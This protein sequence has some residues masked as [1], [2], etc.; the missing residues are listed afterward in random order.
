LGTLRTVDLFVT[1][2]DY[3]PVQEFQIVN[4]VS[5]D[6]EKRK[7]IEDFYND[8]VLTDEMADDLLSHFAEA[9]EVPKSLSDSISE[10]FGEAK[11][12]KERLRNMSFDELI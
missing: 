3:K 2:P 4:F 1:T 9:E 8:G 10:A 5:I 7:E 12:H 11:D 6:M